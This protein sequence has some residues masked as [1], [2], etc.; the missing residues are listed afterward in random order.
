MTT[1]WPQPT[2]SRSFRRQSSQSNT[3]LI[4]TSKTVQENIWTKYNSQNNA[5]C[6]K[7]KLPW[8]SR[9]LQHLARKWH[10]LILRH[11]RAHRHC[12]H[13]HVVKTQCCTVHMWNTVKEWTVS[14]LTLLVGHKP[15]RGRKLFSN[16]PCNNSKDN[17][18]HSRT[19]VFMPSNSRCRTALS[20][21]NIW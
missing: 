11:S 7:T 10:W 5:K 14:N 17:I 4:L 6:S 8:F 19:Y 1:R 13:Y 12:N 9:L 2:Q 21:F 18:A 16:K 20:S 3:W 15:Q